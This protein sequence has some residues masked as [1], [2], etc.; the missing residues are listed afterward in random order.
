[1]SASVAL[2]SL[3]VDWNYGFLMLGIGLFYYLVQTNNDGL[4][5]LVFNRVKPNLDPQGPALAG[6]LRRPGLAQALAVQE[7]TLLGVGTQLPGA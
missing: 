5:D 1:M 7:E 4:K 6:H 2:H 3:Y